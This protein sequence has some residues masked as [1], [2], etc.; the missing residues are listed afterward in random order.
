MYEH[1]ENIELKCI[2]EKLKAWQ[3][4]NCYG[5]SAETRKGFADWI[6]KIETRNT[7]GTD[8][9]LIAEVK[10]RYREVCSLSA[11]K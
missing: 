5:F 6:E 11:E 10:S 1:E 4:N 2:N 3:K 7:Y 8:T 9:A